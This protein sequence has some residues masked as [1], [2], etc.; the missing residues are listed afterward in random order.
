MQLYILINH[1]AIAIY[2]IVPYSINLA[3]AAKQYFEI[4]LLVMIYMNG[5][6]HENKG[7]PLTHSEI[8]DGR[9]T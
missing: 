6:E 4:L 1:I 8:S 9:H 5:L 7:I 3:I 2:T